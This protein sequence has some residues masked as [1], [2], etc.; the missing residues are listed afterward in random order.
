MK[1]G[2]GRFL[3]ELPIQYVKTNQ[4]KESNNFPYPVDENGYKINDLTTYLNDNVK[5]TKKVPQRISQISYFPVQPSGESS[6]ATQ[7]TTVEPELLLEQEAINQLKS[8]KN[9]DNLREIRKKYKELE[10][11]SNVYKKA[12]AD[13]YEILK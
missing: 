4:K 9:K 2:I 1:W 5:V 12:L 7:D 3:Y 6:E 11:T 10:S 8:C 13:R